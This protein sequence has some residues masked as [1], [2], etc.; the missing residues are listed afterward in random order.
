[1]G[2]KMGPEKRKLRLHSH[3]SDLGFKFN[4]FFSTN[5]ANYGDFPGKL[6]EMAT[7]TAMMESGY[8]NMPAEGPV[9]PFPR[10]PGE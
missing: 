1:M 8:F 4:T 10:A 7:V 3:M 6:R 2:V 9:S 5:T